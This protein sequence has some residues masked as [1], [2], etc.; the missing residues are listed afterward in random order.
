MRVLIMGANGMLG[1][2][3]WMAASARHETWATLRGTLAGAPWAALFDA[4]R[5]IEGVSA[6]SDAIK[7]A[8]DV[9][10]P[11]VV[12]NA[13]G[14]T[15]QRPDGNDPGAAFVAN[16][17]VPHFLRLQCD[18]TGTRLI[19][20]STDCVFTGTKGGYTES[21]QPDAMDVY[22]LSKRLG[23]IGSP[24]LTLRTSLIGRSL[25]GSAGLVE[26]FLS[27]PGPVPG[28]R[29]AI[30]S[31]L[32]TAFVAETMIQV[33]EEHATLSGLWHLAADPVDKFDLLSRLATAL[34]HDIQIVPAD[35]PV[36]DRSLDDTRFRAETGIARPTWEEMID[37]LA[38]D[39]TRYDQLRGAA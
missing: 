17:F 19:Q 25:V 6:D 35:N 14:L 22:G 8:L 33:I 27:Q 20:V 34:S 15:K 4:E 28:Y 1:H 23:E 10:R 2:R 29:R 9:S 38:S 7:R 32:T 24:H 5:I 30:F 3:V 37:H 18:L 36:I 31:G 16:C 26:W 13:V 11:E 21:D 12:I 39:P